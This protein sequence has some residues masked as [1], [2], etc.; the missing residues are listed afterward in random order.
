MKLPKIVNLN[1]V[2]YRIVSSDNNYLILKK[3][4]TNVANIVIKNVVVEEDLISLS[5]IY[6]HFLHEKSAPA[7][8]YHYISRVLK[9]FPN[10]DV[11][12]VFKVTKA[13]VSRNASN[14]KHRLRAEEVFVK[15]REWKYKQLNNK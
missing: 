15:I 10:K 3:E 1:N 12:E 7:C 2:N 13:N 8:V 6:N 11:S 14:K 4:N 5:D 9:G